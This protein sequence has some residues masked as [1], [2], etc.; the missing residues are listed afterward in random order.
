[1]VVWFALWSCAENDCSILRSSEVLLDNFLHKSPAA[2]TSMWNPA[3][4]INSE[5]VMIWT[6]WLAL[7]FLLYS[8][9]PGPRDHGQPTPAGYTLKYVVN[10]WNC[11]VSRERRA[12]SRR[13]RMSRAA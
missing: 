10:G 5:A 8:Y 3:E 6:T 2:Y 1:M 12:H 13:Q 11:W 7:Q 4:V 9:V